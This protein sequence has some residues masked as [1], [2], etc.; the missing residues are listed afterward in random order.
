VFSDFW[1][2]IGVLLMMNVIEQCKETMRSRDLP[3]LDP[4][5]AHVKFK[6][7]TRLSQ[8]LEA[9]IQSLNEAKPSRCSPEEFHPHPIMRKYSELVFAVA[10]LEEKLDPQDRTKIASKMVLL[11]KVHHSLSSSYSLYLF[12][13]SLSVTFRM[14]HTH[15]NVNFRQW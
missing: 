14:I 3:D 15:N 6:L 10:T 9:N 13:I 4:Y 8:I 1:D 2:A 11:R 7:S 12:R 5:L